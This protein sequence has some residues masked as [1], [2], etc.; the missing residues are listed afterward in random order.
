MKRESS[1][2]LISSSTRTGISLSWESLS[3]LTGD[4]GQGDAK[5]KPLSL[6]QPNSVRHMLLLGMTRCVLAEE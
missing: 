2:R 3:Q 1:F 6:G 5:L 4:R